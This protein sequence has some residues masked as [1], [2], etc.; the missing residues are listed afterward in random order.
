M[1]EYR[2][3]EAEKDPTVLVIRWRENTTVYEIAAVRKGEGIW[4]NMKNRS[5]EILTRS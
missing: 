5:K 2:E 3:I 1:V 4:Q